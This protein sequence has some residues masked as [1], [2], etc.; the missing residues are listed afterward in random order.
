MRTVLL[1]SQALLLLGLVA[2]AQSQQCTCISI[3]S[4][5]S[6]TYTATFSAAATTTFT[7]LTVELKF[8]NAVN[9]LEFDS[10]STEMVDNYN[11]KLQS[12]GWEA[13]PGWQVEFTITPHFSGSKP[14]VVGALMNGVD[15]CGG[16]DDCPSTGMGPY[17]YKQALCMSY[18]F[19]EAQRSGPL[20]SDQRVTWRW[21]SAL[22]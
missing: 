13:E 14:I 9:S 6:G 12:P 5:G 20:P 19:Y 18:L 1:V 11:F 2:G 7:G 15:V 17:D 4:E 10:G 21:D 8:N 22:G 16:S 3:T